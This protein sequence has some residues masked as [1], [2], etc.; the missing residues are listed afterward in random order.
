MDSRLANDLFAAGNQYSNDLLSMFHRMAFCVI[1]H[2]L[3]AEWA[4]QKIHVRTDFDPFMLNELNELSENRFTHMKRV[5]T[6]ADKLFL[7]RNCKGFDVLCDRF[8]KR[9]TKSCY[10][11]ALIASFFFHDGFEVEIIKES[12]IRGSDFDFVARRQEQSISVEVTAKEP[13]PLTVETIKNTLNQKRTQVPAH[14]PAILYVLIPECWTQD[15]QTAEAVL[16]EA[17]GSFF[18]S[19][20]RFNA[21]ILCWQKSIVLGEGR[22]ISEVRLPYLHCSPRHPIHSTDFLNFHPLGDINQLIQRA[23]AKPDE[24]I[25]ELKANL[26]T[27]SS[28]YSWYLAESQKTES[29]IKKENRELDPP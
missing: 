22:V 26:G 4:A 29:S 20:Q 23:K 14:R 1:R 8:R 25:E 9:A 12:G 11:E 7:L 13:V 24:L 5:Q 18:K 21:V 2:Y 27:A 10:E 19:S 16:S 28:F 17:I 15:G 3:G 6:L